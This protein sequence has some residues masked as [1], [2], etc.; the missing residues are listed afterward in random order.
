[1]TVTSVAT[2]NY[3]LSMDRIACQKDMAFPLTVKTNPVIV[4]M[5][6]VEICNAVKGISR[7]K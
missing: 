6:S 7:Y 5:V 1:M 2:T 3:H 4:D